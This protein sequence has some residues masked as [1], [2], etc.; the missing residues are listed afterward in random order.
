MVG[1]PAIGEDGKYGPGEGR[2][3]EERFVVTNSL[4]KTKVDDRMSG[5]RIRRSW[6]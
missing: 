2:D 1:T 6:A 5:R 4:N 3:K